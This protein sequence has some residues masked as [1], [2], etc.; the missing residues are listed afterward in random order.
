MTKLRSNFR[1]SR[2]L[3]LIGALFTALFAIAPSAKAA[4]PG[5]NNLSQTDFDNAIREMSA[6]STYHSVSG[7]STLGTVFGFEF[8]VIAGLSNS[9]KINELSKQVD[10]SADISRLPHGVLKIAASVPLGFT[11]E[12]LFFPETTFSNIKYSQFG[13]SLKWTTSP[14]ML[15]FNLAVRG[16]V[17]GNKMSF[18]QTLQNA[19]TGNVPTAVTVREENSQLGLQFLASPS[20]PFVEPYAGVG[21]VKANGKLAVSGTSTG[22]IFSFTN[23]QSAESAPTTVQYLLGV[24]VNLLI[25]NLGLEYMR[26]FDT[27]TYNAKIAL[28]F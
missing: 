5:F 7:A 11:G 14:A 12:I 10:S 17:T 25:V 8:G 28:T 21:F 22:T 16:F 3:T 24:N 19:S 27:D 6:N 13:G 9:P 26:A 4:G 2:N 20:L 23:A 15:P 1:K 18:D